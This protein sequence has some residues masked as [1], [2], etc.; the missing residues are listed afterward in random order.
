MRPQFS[1]TVWRQP[2]EGV[3]W[4]SRYQLIHDVHLGCPILPR[5][6]T[7]SVKGAT[8]GSRS[9]LHG[10]S[11]FRRASSRHSMLRGAIVDGICRFLPPGPWDVHIPLPRAMGHASHAR[12]DRGGNSRPQAA[13]LKDGHVVQNADRLAA[14]RARRAAAVRDVNSPGTASPIPKYISSGVCPR[15]AEWGSTVLYS[16]TLECHQPTDGRDTIERVEEQP[17][18]FQRTPLGFDHRVRE[19]QSSE[20]QQP[21]QDA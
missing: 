5:K 7:G 3:G 12:E 20:G 16:W 13:A 10:H 4:L 11:G 14:T 6:H 17:L 1:Q 2:N 8:N 18:M 19:F 9:Y 21:A 15:N